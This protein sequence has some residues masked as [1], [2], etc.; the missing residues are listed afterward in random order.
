MTDRAWSSGGGAASGPPA[1]TRAASASGRTG[2]V[3][4]LQSRQHGRNGG[5]VQEE[6][7][8][9]GE[10]EICQ[11]RLQARGRAAG[12]LALE[13]GQTGEGAAGELR[14]RLVRRNALGHLLHQLPQALQGHFHAGGP[15]DAAP[16]DHRAQVQGCQAARGGVAVQGAADDGGHQVR[17]AGGFVQAQGGEDLVRGESPLGQPAWEVLTGGGVGEQGVQQRVR[18]VLQIPVQKQVR[19]AGGAAHDPVDLL[20]EPVQLG[21]ESVPVRLP[22]PGGLPGQRL[23]AGEVLL[24]LRQ[25]SLAGLE[26]PAALPDLALRPA[27]AAQQLAQGL[28]EGEA[29]RFLRP[30]DR[31]AALLRLF[32]LLRRPVSGRGDLP[33]SANGQLAHSKRPLP[34]LFN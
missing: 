29:R 33:V 3:H 34:Q 31:A 21:L 7:S 17:A 10:Q 27:A 5:E 15:V 14:H 30:L 9:P 12:E 25:H 32:R 6:V 11:K 8:L 4:P 20:P 13:I 23:H 16:G 28:R 22:L 19:A 1:G 18:T 24:H 2:G 26:G